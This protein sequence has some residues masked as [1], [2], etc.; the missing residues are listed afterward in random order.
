MIRIGQIEKM[1]GKKMYYGQVVG[2]R[3]ISAYYG[4]RHTI[5]INRYYEKWHAGSSETYMLNHHMTK[6]SLLSNGYLK[7]TKRFVEEVWYT[8]FND[9]DEECFP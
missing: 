2:E 6:W 1:K 8:H 4:W 3:V 7:E 5:T 9:L